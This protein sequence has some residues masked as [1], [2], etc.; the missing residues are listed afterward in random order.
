M[1][2]ASFSKNWNVEDQ[3][4]K[5]ISNTHNAAT[6]AEFK[7]TSEWKFNP[8]ILGQ[9][10]IPSLIEENAVVVEAKNEKKENQSPQYSELESLNVDKISLDDLSSKVSNRVEILKSLYKKTGD[11]KVLEVLVDELLAN[12]QFDEVRNYMTDVDIF[13][14]SIIDKQSYI[15]TYINTLA[16]TDPNS[17]NNFIKFIEQMKTKNLISSD[18]YLFYRWLQRI[19]DWEYDIALETM[20][21]ISNPN[22]TEFTNQLESTIKNYKSQKWMPK[23]YED[24]LISLLA[25]KNWYF[26]IANKIAVYTILEDNDYVLPYQVLAYS[27][28]L[29]KNWD[30]SISYFYDLSFLDI[31]NKNKYDFYLWISYY[32]KWEYENSVTTLYQLIN[33]EKYKMD[34]YRY[35]L[36]NY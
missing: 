9:K 33:D 32:W 2:A 22:Y 24:A 10:E 19:W 26:S 29:T 30:K 28:F 23:Y 35:L 17:M 34:V 12:Y 18:E 5:E 20:K 27:N 21:Q 4:T 3:K 14:S 13:S 1:D 8:P 36:L 15:Y 31:E 6:S 25:L 7:N 11:E 16:V